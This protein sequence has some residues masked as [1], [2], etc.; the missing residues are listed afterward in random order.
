MKELL[1]QSDRRMICGES[2]LIA[3]IGLNAYPDFT[4]TIDRETAL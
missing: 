2:P 3:V 4:G 1:I